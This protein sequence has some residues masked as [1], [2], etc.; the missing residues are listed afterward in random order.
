[1]PDFSNLPR[2][3]EKEATLL[4]VLIAGRELKGNEILKRAEGAIKLGTLHTTLYRMEEKGFVTSREIPWGEN[5]ETR[6][7]YRITGSGSRVYRA[8]LAAIGVPANA[9]P[10]R[11]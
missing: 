8:A 7:T 10:A 9:S 11:T 1:V 3:S 6:R 5:G 2:V 4:E